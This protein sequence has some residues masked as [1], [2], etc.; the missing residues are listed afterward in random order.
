MRRSI[1]FITLALLGFHTGIAVG[2][3][4]VYAAKPDADL[5]ATLHHRADP[6]RGQEAFRVCRGCHLEDGS[7]AGDAVIPLLAG[8]QSTVLIKQVLDIRTGRRHNPKM[9]P[10]TDEMLVEN[11]DVADIAAYLSELPH[12]GKNLVGSGENLER[13]KTLYLKDCALC[14]GDQGEGDGPRFYPGVAG[15]HYPYLVRQAMDIRDETRNNAYPEMVRVLN[16]YSNEDIAA[17]SD[18]MSRMVD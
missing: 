15:Q 8:Q 12:P 7:A 3:E 4:K 18:Y 17:V 9:F 6:E 16:G 5:I 13:G 2:E 10:F 14:H 1:T 11:N